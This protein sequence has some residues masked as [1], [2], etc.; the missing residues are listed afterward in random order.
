MNWF[1]EIINGFS[2]P[3]VILDEG[4]KIRF[5]NDEFKNQL[6]FS[7]SDVIGAAL[8]KIVAPESLDMITGYDKPDFESGEIKL[9]LRHKDDERDYYLAT[10]QKHSNQGEP[11]CFWH[12]NR[13]TEEERLKNELKLVN[14]QLSVEN[15]KLKFSLRSGAMIAW[16]MNVQSGE[17]TFFPENRSKDFFGI[18]EKINKFD[19]LI[20]I[21]HESARNHCYS[22][23][24]KHQQGKTPF[25]ECELP[26]CNAMQEWSWK[27]GRGK[28]IKRN[29][30]GQPLLAF[31]TMQDITYRKEL[32][33]LELKGAENERNRISRDV[34][35]GISQLLTA[36]RF[37]LKN[38]LKKEPDNDDLI[39]VE[40]LLFSAINETRLII[41]NLGMNLFTDRNLKESFE[42]Q[43]AIFQRYYSGEI[44]FFWEGMEDFIN[45]QYAL[46][47]FRIFQ[48]AVNNA[49]KYS[50]ST[51]LDVTV[52]NKDIFEMEIKDNGIGFNADERSAGF[53]MTNMRE[54][55]TATSG[56]LEIKSAPESGTLIKFR[57][58]Q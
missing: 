5:I 34:H 12:F 47:I 54:R 9:H 58:D 36:S 19:E 10:V 41:N 44:E 13:I 28:I 35:D 1:Y 6:G 7:T 27:F 52:S 56:S 32:A 18:N 53:G 30:D 40:S 4:G 15:D 43:I 14:E 49:M 50:R 42:K 22:A 2:D 21:I 51:Q 46:N 20:S 33:D 8:K 48:E 26:M 24:V 37:I 17:M 3:V 29:E 25:F 57:I 38:A 45:K 11:F 55:A 23:M 16:Q 39:E 31:G